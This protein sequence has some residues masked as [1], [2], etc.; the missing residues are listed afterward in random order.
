LRRRSAINPRDVDLIIERLRVVADEANAFLRSR[1]AAATNGAARPL[2]TKSH[3]GRAGGP[4]LDVNLRPPC[5]P[6][7]GL[8]WCRIAS[9]LAFSR[10]APVIES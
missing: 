5:L 2:Q 7:Y 8:L 3:P 1:G 4:P 10:H 9:W 6:S